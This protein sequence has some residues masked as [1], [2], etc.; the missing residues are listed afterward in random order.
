MKMRLGHR[1]QS[2]CCLKTQNTPWRYWRT[3]SIYSRKDLWRSEFC[4][5]LRPRAVSRLRACFAFDE[6]IKSL[7]SRNH[8]QFV[9]QTNT[10]HESGDRHSAKG[11]QTNTL[12][13]RIDT[14]VR[15]I[16]LNPQARHL[17]V[18][19]ENLEAT[20]KISIW[21]VLTTTVIVSKTCKEVK[22]GN[23]LQ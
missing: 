15:Q 12:L 9:L 6:I 13:D 2:L 1:R 17:L 11:R 21:A 8:I 14:K 23:S 4:S 7:R 5:W 18:I 22:M 19:F 20:L 3:P 16:D 10:L